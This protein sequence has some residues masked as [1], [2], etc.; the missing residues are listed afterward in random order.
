MAKRHMERCLTLL[1]II[2]IQIKTT[3]T[4]SCQ[5]QSELLLGFLVGMTKRGDLDFPSDIWSGECWSLLVV[6]GPKSVGA[7]YATGQEQRNNSRKNEEAEPK[8][9][10]CPAVDVTGDG[11]K[12]RCSKEQY[13]IGT[14]NV[15]SM[16]Q[17]KLEVVKQD[18][19]RVNINILGIS[20][21]KWTGNH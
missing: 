5:D 10:Q 15:R 9:K 3:V 13:H 11:S 19:A 16:N 14:W 4:D 12:V 2:E 21:L 7:H 17:G 1:I 20:V 6:I 8:W 18:M